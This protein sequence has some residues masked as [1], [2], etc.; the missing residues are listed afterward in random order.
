MQLT[1]GT[2]ITVGTR[3]RSLA[4]LGLDGEFRT[5]LPPTAGPGLLV[6]TFSPGC[7]ACRAN[8]P[9]WA[10]LAREVEQRGWAVLWVS[11]DTVNITREYCLEEHIPLSAALADPP[12]RTYVQLG[13][14]AVPKTVVV[15]SDGAVEKVWTGL[16]DST[17]WREV[18][19]YFG[20]VERGL[21]PATG[22]FGVPPNGCGPQSLNSERQACK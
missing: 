18:F 14:K 11:R 15:R 8:Q 3:L 19:A 2:A 7:P 10:G 1:A 17:G 16:L 5:V 22:A 12:Y 4:G 6:I 9:G 21:V 13:L 20:T